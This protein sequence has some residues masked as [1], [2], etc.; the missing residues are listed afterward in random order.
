MLLYEDGCNLKINKLMLKRRE[1]EVKME[2]MRSKLR[3]Q[4]AVIVAM[5]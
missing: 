2:R 5:K 1:F 3:F 4:T